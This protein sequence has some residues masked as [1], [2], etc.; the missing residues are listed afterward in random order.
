MKR[1]NGLLTALAAL[2]T[3][4]LVAL[5][6]YAWAGGM[7]AAACKGMMKMMD[8][9]K[10]TLAKAIEAG[11]GMAKGK[12]V[13]AMAMMDGGKLMFKVYCMAGDKLSMVMVDGTG[14]AMK[15][16]DAKMMD[17]SAGGEMKKEEAKPAPKGG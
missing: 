3:L 9:G 6:V 12:A 13:G 7:D 11:E 2:G 16:D 15:M 8:D 4:G 17:M 14:K 5:P 10:I 1:T